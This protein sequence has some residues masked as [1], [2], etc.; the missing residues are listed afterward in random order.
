MSAYKPYDPL[1]VPKPFADAVWVIDGP[2]IR[3]DLGP[4]RI[5]FPTRAT[6]VRLG[7]GSLLVHSPTA[8]EEEL[9]L[10]IDALGPVR[11]IVAPNTLH[12]WF[13]RDWLERYPKAASYAVPGLEEGAKRPFRIDHVLEMD[14][15]FDWQADVDWLLVPGT[16]ITEAVFFVRSSGVLILT[17]LIENFEPIRVK[18]RLQRWAIQLFRANGSLP[19][20]ARATFLP[21]MGEVRRQVGKMLEWPVEQVTMTHGKPYTQNAPAELRRAFRW[22]MPR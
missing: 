10:A 15:Q 19:Y 6:L 17:D 5:P 7:D 22:A 9:F 12:Y 2:E 14:A 16:T 20:D 4:F 21:K 8:P 18:N 3:M 13:M 11:H 1:N